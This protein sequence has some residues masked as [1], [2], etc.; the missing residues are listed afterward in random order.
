MNDYNAPHRLAALLLTV[1]LLSGCAYFAKKKT[2][3]APAATPAPAPA[4][5]QAPPPEASA[6]PP[7][8]PVLQETAPVR[9]TVK[10]GD[11]LWAIAGLYLKDPASWPDIWYANSGIKNPHLIYPGDV[12]VLNN[13]GGHPSLS[14][15]R[16]GQVVTETSPPPTAPTPASTS[17]PIPA[18]EPVA[19][20]P[21][22][23]AAAPVPEP[24]LTANL[25]VTKIEPQIRYQPLSEAVP[26]LPLA[27]IKAYLSKTRVVSKNELSNA[28]YIIGSSDQR[29]DMGVG[30]EVYAR[31]VSETNG[32]RYDLFR[33]DDPY[34]DPENGD[35]LGYQATYIGNATVET[36]GDPARLILTLS[37]QEAEAG[38]RLLPVSA[39][40]ELDAN[41]MPHRPA[42]S[43]QGEIMAVLG[44]VEEIGQ[45]QVVV[46]NRGADAGLDAGAV[47]DIYRGGATLD[48]SYSPKFFGGGTIKVPPEHSGT[49]M[50]FRTFKQVSYALVMQA[51]HE[52]HLEDTV[53]SP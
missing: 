3:P 39:D 6:P 48:D 53:A 24:E 15:E 26:T 50:V 5:I 13:V 40:T 42:K 1:V 10:K 18:S 51:T 34:V 22:P 9:Y 8:A 43:V 14:V 49:L 4:T 2:A 12:L 36:W 32:G 29:P 7:P 16:D 30:D 19:A 46:L 41:F 37:P 27:S 52:I 23:A 33:L 20:N 25:P 11:T 28:G 45:Y 38:D 47:L 44:G 35:K 31:G 17:N 21:A